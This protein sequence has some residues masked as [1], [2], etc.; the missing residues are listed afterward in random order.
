MRTPNFV[1]LSTAQ[2]DVMS[3][4]FRLLIEHAR[5]V[6][7]VTNNGARYLRGE[8]MKSVAVMEGEGGGYSILVDR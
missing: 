3:K 8:E 6:V 7:Q 4:K 5:Q 1:F 2:C